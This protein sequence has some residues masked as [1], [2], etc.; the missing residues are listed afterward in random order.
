LGRFGQNQG[1]RDGGGY[2][3]VGELFLL[4]SSLVER[5][6]VRFPFSSIFF[7]LFNIFLSLFFFL[8]FLLSIFLTPF[9]LSA[10]ISLYNFFSHNYSLSL[11]L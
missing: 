2:G 3:L 8:I 5:E 7:S 9:F 6:R 1:D 11:S 4:F 10:H